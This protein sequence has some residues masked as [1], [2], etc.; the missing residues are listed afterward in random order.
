MHNCRTVYLA[1]TFLARIRIELHRRSFP[2]SAEPVTPS[3]RRCVPPLSYN[4][5]HV[6]TSTFSFSEGMHQRQT[7]SDSV[8]QRVTL[9]HFIAAHC[10]LLLLTA[11][12][13]P[14]CMLPAYP[15]KR[16]RRFISIAATISHTPT[17]S[18]PPPNAPLQFHPFPDLL[19]Q[20]L[21]FL[22]RH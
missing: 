21:P 22:L 6:T 3:H 15:H 17:H 20:H 19:R 9:M 12:C 2:A 11:H 13:S 14:A 1:S 4:G 8:R 5:P 18:P 16:A 7:A 10:P